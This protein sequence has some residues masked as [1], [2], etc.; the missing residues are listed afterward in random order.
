MQ[1]DSHPQSARPESFL[2]PFNS[3]PVAPLQDHALALR[4]KLEGERPQLR[5][6]T[7]SKL[8]ILHVG[9]QLSHPVVLVQPDGGDFGCELTSECR[10]ARGRKP[11][12]QHEPRR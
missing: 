1:F 12:D 4:E 8:V 9:A 6:D 11:T 7:G 2:I 5:L 10:L 3:R